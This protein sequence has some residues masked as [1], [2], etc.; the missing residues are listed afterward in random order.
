MCLRRSPPKGPHY[1]YTT[2][3]RALWKESVVEKEKG[4][5]VTG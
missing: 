3:V 1:N 5:R 2:I 4:L